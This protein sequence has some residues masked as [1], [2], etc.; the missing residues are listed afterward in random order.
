MEL[1]EPKFKKFT[2]KQLV[3]AVVDTMICGA[4][5]IAA[6][7]IKFYLSLRIVITSSLFIHSSTSES[8][9]R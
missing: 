6:S 9:F 7:L 4:I 5:V 3:R 2:A 1:K 8:M